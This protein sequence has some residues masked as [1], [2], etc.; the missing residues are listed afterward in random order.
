[1]MSHSP[2]SSKRPSDT[3]AGVS[4]KY[5]FIDF[6]KDNF[7]RNLRLK[8]DLNSETFVRIMILGFTPLPRTRQ[9]E[10][11]AYEINYDSEL[12]DCFESRARSLTLT[13]IRANLF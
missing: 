11:V 10:R 4:G 12:F 9:M 6:F 13:L 2:F 5:Y 8:M 3:V 1:M 7:P